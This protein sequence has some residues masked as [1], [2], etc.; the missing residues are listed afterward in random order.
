M[1]ITKILLSTF[2]ALFA[3]IVVPL[4]HV[5]AEETVSLENEIVLEDGITAKILVDN[6]EIKSVETKDDKNIYV[7]TYYKKTDEM[8]YET[9]DLERNLIIEELMTDDLQSAASLQTQANNGTLIRSKSLGDSY[10]YWVYSYNGDYIWLTTLRPT[11]SKN[12]VEKSTNA[13]ALNSYKLSVDRFMASK[14]QAV[15]KVG[16]GIL[17]TITLLYLVPEPVWTKVVA[18][19]LTIVS[20]AI[21]YAEGKAMY[22][23]YLDSGYFYGRI[24]F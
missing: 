6:R 15:V 20:S 2:M 24:T 7:A 23:A 14:D 1:K 10:G 22:D 21:A 13:S 5:H 17:S 4:F 3:M 8:K 12:P 16:T 19:L 11:V 18:G 9:Y